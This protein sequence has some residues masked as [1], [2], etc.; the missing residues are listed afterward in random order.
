MGLTLLVIEGGMH[1]D[2]EALKKIGV[3]ALCIGYFVLFCFLFFLFKN[4]KRK[5]ERKELSFF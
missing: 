3:K 1:V 5:R 2:L 4:V